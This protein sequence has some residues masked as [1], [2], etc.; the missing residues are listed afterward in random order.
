MTSDKLNE[1]Q[2]MFRHACAFAE[3]ADLAREK[4]R[5]NTADI[6]WYITPSVV[7]SAFACE[8]YLKA[9]LI[10]YNVSFKK[11]HEIKELYGLLPDDTRDWVKQA[12]IACSGGWEDALGFERLDNISDAFVKWRYSFENDWSKSSIMRIDV[13]FLTAFRNV[14]REACCQ[15]FF[16]KTWE[17]YSTN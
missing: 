15:L 1:C 14:L 13:G 8:V 17:E 3:C 12:T 16:K 2:K 10:F 4:F 5:H 7:N 9:L 11:K 6:D